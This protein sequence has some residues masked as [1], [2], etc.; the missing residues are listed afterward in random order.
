MILH[1]TYR[2]VYENDESLHFCE[3]FHSRV[4]SSWITGLGLNLR[5]L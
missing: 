1:T 3:V 5:Y 4:M 2:V